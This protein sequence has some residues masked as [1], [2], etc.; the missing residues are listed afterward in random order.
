MT[1]SLIKA[2]ENLDAIATPAPWFVRPLGDAAGLHA[3][4]ITCVLADD[5]ADADADRSGES[6]VAACPIWPPF[7]VASGHGNADLIVELRNALPQLLRLARL[8][9]AAESGRSGERR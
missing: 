8:G 6:I 5:D 1:L 7:D 2:L 4:A 9:L 3:V